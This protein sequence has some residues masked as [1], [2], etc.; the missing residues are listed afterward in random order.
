MTAVVCGRNNPNTSEWLSW[1]VGGVGG[2]GGSREPVLGKAIDTF[3]FQLTAVALPCHATARAA[4]LVV[5]GP[6]IP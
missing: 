6:V 4:T 2:G 3:L 1:G 5:S